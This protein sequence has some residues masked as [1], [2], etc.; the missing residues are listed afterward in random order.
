[1]DF[2]D[3]ASVRAYG[4][5]ETDEETASQGEDIASFARSILGETEYLILIQH[6]VAERKFREI[7][8]ELGRAEATVRWQYHQALKKVRNAWERREHAE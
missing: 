8:A 2:S 3:E 7:A 1:M 4:I 6:A 5:D